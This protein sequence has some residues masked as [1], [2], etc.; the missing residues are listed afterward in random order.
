MSCGILVVASACLQPTKPCKKQC[1]WQL[2]WIIR[3]SW[4]A[5]VACYSPR[6]EVYFKQFTLNLRHASATQVLAILHS[7]SK[8][9][10]NT[11]PPGNHCSKRWGSTR[12]LHLSYPLLLL[13]SIAQTLTVC[14]TLGGR[15]TAH[16][17]TC[18]C[19]SLGPHCCHCGPKGEGDQTIT[20]SVAFMLD[21]KV[22]KL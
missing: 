12:S 10:R 4:F 21:Q 15:H 5:Q 8:E 18:G 22:Q 7:Q 17:A 19:I 14:C 11:R 6:A 20:C 9:D 1:G 2:G 16:R 3:M 13:Q